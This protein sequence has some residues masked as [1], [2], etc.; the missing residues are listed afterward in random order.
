MI[1]TQD[2]TIILTFFSLMFNAST[3]DPRQ[4]RVD[5]GAYWQELLLKQS[6]RSKGL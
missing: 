6:E 3:P 2:T 5:K 1:I 4:I